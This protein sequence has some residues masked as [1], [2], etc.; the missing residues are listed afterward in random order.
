MTLSLA[1]CDGGQKEENK[2]PS[3]VLTSN[4]KSSLPYLSSD[5]STKVNMFFQSSD[6][7]QLTRVKIKVGKGPYGPRKGMIFVYKD[8]THF[9]LEKHAFKL[10]GKK[11]TLK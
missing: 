1:G 9:H 11:I 3:N 2:G 8:E 5:G 7:F 10:K 6:C 4:W